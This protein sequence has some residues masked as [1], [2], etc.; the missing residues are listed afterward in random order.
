MAITN[1]PF[2]LYYGTSKTM[3]EATDEDREKLKKAC[4]SVAP[5]VLK[6]WNEYHLSKQLEDGGKLTKGEYAEHVQ[7]MKDAYDY[8]TAA[9]PT[10]D[11]TPD[12]NDDLCM[13][14]DKAQADEA[15]KHAW[16]DS[17]ALAKATHW[18]YY[19]VF[20]SHISFHEAS[21]QQ[22]MDMGLFNRMG[23][24]ELTPVVVKFDNV[25]ADKVVAMK[26]GKEMDLE[27][28]VEAVKGGAKDI[29]FKATGLKMADGVA[30]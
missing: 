27:A 24:V 9:Y 12:Y 7:D 25:P 15:A 8:L 4:Y 29:C 28:A 1:L 6:L 16:H 22:T 23:R 18:V 20:E 14:V 10:P 3:L 30:L 2:T 13:K 21:F 17:A 19:A 11:A 5:Y 26:D